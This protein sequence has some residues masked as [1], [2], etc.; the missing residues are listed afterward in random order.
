ME[1]QKINCASCG[2]PIEVPDDAD[3]IKCPYCGS[4]LSVK[5]DQSDISLQIAEKVGQAVEQSGS[6]SQEAIRNGTYVT[7][8][9][10]KRLQV[11]QDLS[12]LQLQLNNIQSEIRSLEREK[13]DKLIENQIVELRIQERDLKQRIQGLQSV[14]LSPI[15]NYQDG[16][17]QTSSAFSE[18]KVIAQ[19]PDRVRRERRPMSGK[20]LLII[21]GCL[22][23]IGSCILFLF[24]ITLLDRTNGAAFTLEGYL[25]ALII[26]PLPFILLGLGLALFGYFRI[27]KGKKGEGIS[28]SST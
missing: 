10:L 3:L 8:S 24:L 15:S 4:Q 17:S 27:R 12:M 20:T 16:I 7:Q 11:G 14:L 1:I 21:G 19:K 2:S 22:F 9:E 25:G 28:G 23:L 6:A 26:C 18:P 5:K 13:K